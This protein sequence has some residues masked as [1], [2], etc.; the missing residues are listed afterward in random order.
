MA[1]DRL[2]VSLEC[3][4]C[5]VPILMPTRTVYLPGRAELHF[6][7]APLREHVAGHRE[8]EDADADP[9]AT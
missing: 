7:T 1:A 8:Q 3:P 4:A 5:L 9:S 6:D 2:A